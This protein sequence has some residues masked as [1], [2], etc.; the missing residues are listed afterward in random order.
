MNEACLAVGGLAGSPQPGREPSA[1][2]GAAHHVL[3]VVT[4]AICGRHVDKTF[5]PYSVNERKISV[6]MLK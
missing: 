1:R 5:R 6:S 4:K 2:Q 3:S